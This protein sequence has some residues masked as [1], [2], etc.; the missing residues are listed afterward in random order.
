MHKLKSLKRTPDSA[1]LDQRHRRSAASL[2]GLAAGDALGVTNEFKARGSFRPVQTLQGGGPFSVKLKPGEWTDDT[3]M[4]LCLGAS[5]LEAGEFD[6]VDQLR[7]YLA[8]YRH[9]YLSS[10]GECFDIGRTTVQALESFAKTGKAR[11][12][13]TDPQSSGN[14]SLMRLAPVV[15]AYQWQPKLAIKLA[16]ESSRTTHGSL[17]CVDA[18]RYYAALLLGALEGRPK[19]DLLSARYP[20]ADLVRD[21]GGLCAEIAAVARGGYKKKDESEIKTTPFVVTSLE[22]ALWCFHRTGTFQEGALLAANLGG[23]AD[24]IAAIYGMLA[25]AYYGEAVD[26]SADDGE[27]VMFASIGNRQDVSEP[28]ASAGIPAEWTRLLARDVFIRTVAAHLVEGRTGPVEELAERWPLKAV[29]LASVE[30]K[31]FVFAEKGL[32]LPVV[33]REVRTNRKGAELSLEVVPKDKSPKLA[34]KTLK[35]GGSWDYLSVSD[36]EIGCSGVG[37]RLMTAP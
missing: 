37:W 4:A 5:L 22:A 6:A 20:Y 2:L 32:K 25:G 34:A 29:A 9:G 19:E 23:D 10:V 26:E 27:T 8:W 31:R 14:G 1:E 33:V 36:E 28:A 13:P 16:G 24:T 3:S 15:V 7:H 30:G 12:G 17:M 35:I 11:S 18:C 21:S